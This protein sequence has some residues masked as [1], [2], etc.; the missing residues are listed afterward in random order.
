MEVKVFSTAGEEKKKINLDDTVFGREVNQDAVYQAIRNELANMRVGTAATKTRSEVV[1]SHQKPWRQKGTGRARAGTKQS[2]VWVG[3]GVAFGPA[4]RNYSYKVPRKIKRLAMK[5]I[6][7]QVTRDERLKVV[8][9]FTIE[10]G[11]TKSLAALL[12]ALVAEERTVLITEGDDPMLK[13][14]GRN[15]PWLTFLSYNRLRA[16][17]LFYGRNILLMEKA[18]EKLNEFY[19]GK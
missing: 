16:H 9:D 15:I 14:A 3:G 6:L 18:A 17:D 13:R 12:K 4:N 5:S 8:E 1:G 7:S 10:D 2:P 19:T 11:K